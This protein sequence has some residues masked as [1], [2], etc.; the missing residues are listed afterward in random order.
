M[1]IGRIASAYVI[2]LVAIGVGGW[3]A[4]QMPHGYP[5]FFV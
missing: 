1:R 4:S 3:Q 5:T 2:R